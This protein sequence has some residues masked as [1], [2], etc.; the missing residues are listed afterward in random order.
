MFSLGGG[1]GL[2][3]VGFGLIGL[4]NV[5][6]GMSGARAAGLAAVAGGRAETFLGRGIGAIF[7]GQATATLLT[8]PAFSPGDWRQNWFSGL[9]TRLRRLLLLFVGPF[10]WLMWFHTYH[11]L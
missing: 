3:T 10:L 7:I 11:R 4:S 8:A 9:A 5:L 1:A 2:G 6:R